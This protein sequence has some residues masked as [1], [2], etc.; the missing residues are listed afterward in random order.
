MKNSLIGIL[1]IN[2]LTCCN[3]NS[4]TKEKVMISIEKIEEMYSNMKSNGVDITSDFLYGYFFI[5]KE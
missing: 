1:I 5:S 2:F 4:Q 3:V